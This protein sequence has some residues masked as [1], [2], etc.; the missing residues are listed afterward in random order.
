[1]FLNQTINNL[2]AI[3]TVSPCFDVYVAGFGAFADISRCSL[4]L[5][6]PPEESLAAE[7]SFSPVMD[8]L[9]RELITNLTL[10]KKIITEIMRL[11]IVILYL[12]SL[13]FGK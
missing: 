2:P 3:L 5:Y 11:R 4:V 6:G 1:M 10:K 7:A 13:F 9:S 8:M 12:A